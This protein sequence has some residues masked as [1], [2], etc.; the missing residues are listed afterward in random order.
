MSKFEIGARVEVLDDAIKGSILKL[1]KRS[2]IVRTTD[3]F[4]MEFYLDELVVISDESSFEVSN[5]EVFHAL[6]EKEATVK[7]R[8]FT[9]K[10]KEK[11]APAMEVDLHIEKL[12]TKF[13][14]MTNFDMLNL[15][16]DTARGQLEFAISKR[17]QRVVF[18]HGMGEGV[19]KSE[20]NFLFSRYDCI[21]FYD[22]NYREYGLG[23]TEVYI[24]QSAL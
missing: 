24:H 19:L 18:I 4:D 20:L 12:T 10:K 6:S 22:A 1:D 16:L 13:K 8:S 17:I 7:K 21:S 9:K 11:Q 2:A 5:I 23:A 15:Q 14:S 3:G